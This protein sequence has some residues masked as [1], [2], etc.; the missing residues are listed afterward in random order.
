MTYARL[1]NAYM[2]SYMHVYEKKQKLTGAKSKQRTIV[3]RIQF[4]LLHNDI[5]A[6]RPKDTELRSTIHFI[7]GTLVWLCSL[8]T[9]GI[10]WRQPGQP[11]PSYT[12]LYIL[13]IQFLYN[14]LFYKHL[15]TEIQK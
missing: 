11:L 12:I 15:Q 5:C 3:L 6:A 1:D 9:W 13:R 10:F 7:E 8:K 4:S 14:T 2:M